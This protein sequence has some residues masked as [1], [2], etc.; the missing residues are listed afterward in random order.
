MEIKETV[1]SLK[2]RGVNGRGLNKC[3]GF[4]SLFR[5]MSGGA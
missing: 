5:G 3:K 2:L 1:G 4:Q